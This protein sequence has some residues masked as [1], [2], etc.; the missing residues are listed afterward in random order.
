MFLAQNVSN[1]VWFLIP[2]QFYLDYRFILYESPLKFL[3]VIRI[4][5]LR[6]YR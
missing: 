2:E 5:R 3:F 4:K 1:I 6:V